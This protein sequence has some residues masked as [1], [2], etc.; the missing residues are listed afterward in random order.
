[1]GYRNPGA[2]A[3]INLLLGGRPEMKLLIMDQV[4]PM[5]PFQPESSSGKNDLPADA[6]GP[7]P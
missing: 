4:F 6:Q 7:N 1:M 3:M 2:T 5:E